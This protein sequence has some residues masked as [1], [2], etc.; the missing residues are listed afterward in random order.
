MGEKGER[1]RRRTLIAKGILG[2]ISFLVEP[3]TAYEVSFNIDIYKNLTTT[4]NV[5]NTCCV[6][7]RIQMFRIQ[8]TNNTY[9][10]LHV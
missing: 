1:K 7:A 2:R 10:T 9:S 8:E 5:Y 4:L 6:R 3:F